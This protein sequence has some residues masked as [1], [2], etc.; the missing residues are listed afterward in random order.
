MLEILGEVDI[1]CHFGIIQRLFCDC[2]A[3]TD[4]FA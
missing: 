1:K 4:D 3:K 2:S